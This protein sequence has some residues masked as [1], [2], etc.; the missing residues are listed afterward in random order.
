MN[1][2]LE[3]VSEALGTLAGLVDQVVRWADRMLGGGGDATK[4]YVALA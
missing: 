4:T 2:Y 3:R 1:R